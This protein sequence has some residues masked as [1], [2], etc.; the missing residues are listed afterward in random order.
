MGTL[1]NRLYS[2]L[3]KPRALA[4]EGRRLKPVQKILV[5]CEGPNPTFSYYLGERLKALSIPF[6]VHFPDKGLGSVVP[7]GLFVVIVRYI[8]PRSLFWLITNRNRLSGIALLVDDDIAATCVAPDVD[9]LYRLH[10]ARLGLLPLP[11]LNRVLTHLWI[12]TPALRNSIGAGTVVSP[13]P[14]LPPDEQIDTIGD[15]CP[16]TKDRKTRCVMAFHSTGAHNAEHRFLMPIVEKALKKHHDLTFEVIAQK[17][18]RRAWYNVLVPFDSRGVVVDALNWAEYVRFCA[19][20]PRDIVLVPLLQNSV[21]SVRADT[22]RIDIA[23]MGAAAVFSASS[24]YERCFTPGEIAVDHR[25]ECWLAAIDELLGSYQRRIDAKRATRTSLK[26]MRQEAN[27]SLPG[28]EAY[29]SI[30]RSA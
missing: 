21:N 29:F 5:L 2:M 17:S 16:G 20:K 11:F 18:M 13:F 6:D 14:P 10:I 1:R 27:V 28:L 4:A 9:P 24:T 8:R 19:G 26:R 23:R 25:P 15:L 3:P 7:D 12:S 30:G 22:K